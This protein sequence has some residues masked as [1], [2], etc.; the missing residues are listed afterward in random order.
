MIICR[1]PLRI[2]LFGG[3]SDYPQWY[4]Q[5]GGAVVGFAIDKYVYISVRA[6]PPFFDHKHRIV[7]SRAETVNEIAEIQHPAVRAVFAEMGVTEGLEL[8][9]DGDLPARSG[10][11]SS[12]SFTVGLLNALHAY[13]GRMVPKKALA[14]QA[15]HVE[16]DVIGEH[17]GS[18]DQIWAA[19]GGFNRI[20]FHHDGGFDVR[21][22]VLPLARR[23]TIRDSMMLFFTGLSRIASDVARDQIRNLDRRRTHI[24]R[25][26][27][28]V[29]EAIGVITDPKA[30][31]RVLGEMLHD[32]W[33]LKRELAD[34]VSN[35]AVDEIYA[36]ARAAG[37]IGGKL[38]GA[39][40]GGFMLLIVDKKDQP[41]VR[42]RLRRLV[43][44]PV[45]FDLSGSK[46]VVYEPK[47]LQHC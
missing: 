4:H 20:D 27:A 40:G 33:M 41:K 11:G 2:S 19:Y 31:A 24:D 32:S 25:M 15:I 13:A 46:I 21:P 37:A 26:V 3:G 18:Q 29:D 10:T 17:V 9:H 7:Y 39:G 14:E 34:R 45:D 22:I 23:E 6:L 28:M 38:L 16:Q 44:T 12:S 47:G 43:A 36:E 42:E 30:P 1:T 35:G 8:H 5:H